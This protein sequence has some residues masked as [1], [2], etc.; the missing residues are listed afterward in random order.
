[1]MKSTEHGWTLYVIDLKKSVLGRQS[2]KAANPDYVAGKPCVYVGVTYLTAQERF[3]QHMNGIRSSRIVRVYG[4][5]V[6][7]KDCRILL[8]MTRAHAEKK[9]AAYAA[10]L[11]ARGWGAWSN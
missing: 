9:E 6:R 1:M 11:R 4:K 2:F 10:R 8:T 5:H 7:V 3:E